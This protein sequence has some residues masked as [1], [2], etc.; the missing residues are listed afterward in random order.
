MVQHVSGNGNRFYSYADALG[1]IRLLSD[2]SGNI[3]ESYTYDPYGRPRVM[4]AGGADGNWLTE[5]TAVYA[6][7]HPLLY[8]NPYLFTGRRWDSTTELYYYRMRDYSP[9][10]GRFMQPDP[11]GYIDG[12]NLYAYC[13]NNPLNWIDPWGL[14][15]E[16]TGVWE[17]IKEDIKDIWQ[18][19]GDGLAIFNGQ[20]PGWDYAMDKMGYETSQEVIM[21]NGSAGERSNYFAGASREFFIA[22]AFAGMYTHGGTAL[23]AVNQGTGSAGLKYTNHGL[24]QALG[25]DE[26]LGVAEWVL[27][28]AI[29]HPLEVIMQSGGRIKYIGRYAV[30]VLNSAGEVITCW[31]KTSEA[32]AK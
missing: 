3:K 25:R 13:G 20:I 21:R 17:Q 27:K 14:C 18:A 12:M 11:A 15:R 2:S 4:R 23:G 30:V 6:S 8:G 19:I 9:D 24:T 10:A 31:A 29:A 7:S 28:D 16:D 22:A 26:S 1:L 5:D 32:Y